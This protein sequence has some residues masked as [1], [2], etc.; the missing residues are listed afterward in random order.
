[1]KMTKGVIEFYGE[2]YGKWVKSGY[3]AHLDPLGD[4]F[5]DTLRY[6]RYYQYQYREGENST[7]LP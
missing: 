4:Y 7:I 2:F 5:K 6:S 1:M 3:N